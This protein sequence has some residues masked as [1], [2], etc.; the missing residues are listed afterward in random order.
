M[1][2]IAYEI[3]Q[4]EQYKLYHYSSE[5]YITTA[6]TNFMSKFNNLADTDKSLIKN[7]ILKILNTSQTTKPLNRIIPIP[8]NTPAAVKIVICYNT[9]AISVA[10]D[11][12]FLGYQGFHDIIIYNLL[13]LA[14]FINDMFSNNSVLLYSAPTSKGVPVSY[15][16]RVK[17]K[18]LNSHDKK[19]FLDKII[20]DEYYSPK[21]KCKVPFEIIKKELVRNKLSKIERIDDLSQYGKHLIWYRFTT[22]YSH[23]PIS[24]IAYALYS[25][26]IDNVH[27]S[28]DNYYYLKMLIRHKDGTYKHAHKDCGITSDKNSHDIMTSISYDLMRLDFFGRFQY[29]LFDILNLDPEKID[30]VICLVSEELIKLH[31]EDKNM[32]KTVIK[33]KVEMSVKLTVK[34]AALKLGLLLTRQLHDIFKKE[35]KK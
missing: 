4:V 29:K 27:S 16:D 18:K 6:N 34:E 5:Y 22:A 3:M 12:G 14:I 35:D 1:S 11:N 31:I 28:R 30:I 10:L 20:N 25:H 26:L 24:V 7:D 23:L 32:T 13:L 17:E 19:V 9:Y 33:D 15:Q 2:A 21:H 8:S